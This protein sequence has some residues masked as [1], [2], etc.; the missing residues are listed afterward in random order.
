MIK[1]LHLHQALSD[2]TAVEVDSSDS[3]FYKNSESLIRVEPHYGTDGQSASTLLSTL[4]NWTANHKL[5]GLCYLA[6]R[7]KWNQDAFTGVP[8][9]Q[10]KIQG[11]KVETYNASLVAQSACLLKLIQHGAY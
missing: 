5:S 9:V 3:N 10:A 7:F 6:I 11:K 8:K 1:L 4:T 2:G